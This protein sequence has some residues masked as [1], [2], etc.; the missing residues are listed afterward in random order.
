MNALIPICNIDTTIFQNRIN[1]NNADQDNC[2]NI[3]QQLPIPILLLQRNNNN[4]NYLPLM[5]LGR[6]WIAY[7]SF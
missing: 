7:V 1:K 5:Q 2:T 3:Y 6:V 4:D